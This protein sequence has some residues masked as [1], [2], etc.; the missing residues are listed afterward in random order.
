MDVAEHPLHT[1]Y[2]HKCFH[3]GPHSALFGA[4]DSAY[5]LHLKALVAHLA[6]GAFPLQAQFDISFTIAAQPLVQTLPVIVTVNAYH[7]NTFP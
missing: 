5:F 1:A 3:F 6:A 2:A 7:D 4:F